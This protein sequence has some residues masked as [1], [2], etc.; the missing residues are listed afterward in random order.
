MPCCRRYAP[1]YG[2]PVDAN[3]PVVDPTEW[4]GE[5]EQKHGGNELLSRPVSVL[6]LRVNTRTALRR[7]NVLTLG[8][9]VARGPGD[10]LAL[11]NFGFTSLD[12][13]ER[14]LAGVGLSLAG[15][16]S[17]RAKAQG[18]VVARAEPTTPAAT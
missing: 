4:C 1:R 7:A 2:L 5:W 9:L 6:T 12:Q 13:V 10:L 3:W 11:R 15:G 8:D 18:V 16:P 17:M 14:E